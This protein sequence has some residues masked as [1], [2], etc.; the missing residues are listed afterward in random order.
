MPSDDKDEQ[1]GQDE[2]TGSA[3]GGQADDDLDLAKVSLVKDADDAD[4]AAEEPEAPSPS[5]EED[6]PAD[7]ADAEP[8]A[9]EEAPEPPASRLPED[10]A[11]QRAVVEAILF[12]S[13]EPMRPARIAKNLSADSATVRR[14]IQDLADEYD[15]TGRAFQ[16]VA[17]AGGF[18]MLTREEYA[19]Y[20]GEFERE[21]SSARISSAAL[22]TLAIV[23]YRQPIIRAEIEKIRGVGC[24]PILR[25]LLDKGLVRIA[26]RADQLGSPLLYATTPKFLEHFGLNSLR[27]LPRSAEFRAG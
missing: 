3:A 7:N 16:I 9:A 10:E 27:D 4:D 12:A 23:A 8:E 11:Q 26:G 17:V 2:G 13:P 1:L 19:P 20:M 25:T 21:R 5:D 22:E 24:G 15:R 14:L 18:Q 6:G